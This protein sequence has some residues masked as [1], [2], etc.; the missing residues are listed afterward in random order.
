MTCDQIKEQLLEDLSCRRS[1]EVARH[2]SECTACAT[3]VEELVELDQLVSMLK[4]QCSAPAGFRVDIVSRTSECRSWR[5]SYLRPVVFGALLLVAGVVSWIT[6]EGPKHEQQVLDAPASVY[7]D[8]VQA[9][10]T[11]PAFVEVVVTDSSSEGGII[12]RLPTVIEIRQ[13]EV[14]EDFYLRNVS[15]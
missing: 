14:A 12:L 4:D 10:E 9:S 7:S 11:D 5:G 2:L 6:L 1:S 3:L 8:T 13:T 15:H